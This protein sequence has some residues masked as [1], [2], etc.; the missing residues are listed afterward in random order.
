M[1]KPAMAPAAGFSI[2]DT[3]RS[4]AAVRGLSLLYSADLIDQAIINVASA[5]RRGPPG[6]GHE[7]LREL[8]DAARLVDERARWKAVGRVLDGRLMR[9]IEA[10]AR[11]RKKAKL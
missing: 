6:F 7:E 3:L 5:V 11:Q 1:V 4:I 2:E 9:E 10:I 8:Q